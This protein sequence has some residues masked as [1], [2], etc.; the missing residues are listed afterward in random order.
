MNNTWNN[1][2][3]SGKQ[4]NEY[5]FEFV[6]ASTKKYIKNPEKKRVLDLGCGAGNHIS[7]FYNSKF[8]SVTGIDSSEIVTNLLKKKYVKNNKINILNNDIIENDYKKNYFD[9]ALDRMTVTHNNIDKIKI[10]VNKL[11]Y[12]IKKNGYLFSVCF[13]KNHIEYKKNKNNKK[14]F[15][16]FNKKHGIT[17]T[18]MNYSDIKEIYYKFKKISVNENIIIDNKSKNKIAFWFLVLKK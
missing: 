10:I 9:L 12:T 6:I 16:K 2:Y 15:T 11:Y 8:K 13:S 7:F 1:I 5:P 17:S 14:Y 4:L 3:K 18:F